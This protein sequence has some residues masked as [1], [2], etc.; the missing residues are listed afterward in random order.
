MQMV[1]I[2]FL[3]GS[4]GL[5]FPVPERGNSLYWALPMP[6]VDPGWGAEDSEAV[7]SWAPIRL[8]AYNS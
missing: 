5:A 8:I 3:N 2:K 1:R 7:G 6:S 4:I